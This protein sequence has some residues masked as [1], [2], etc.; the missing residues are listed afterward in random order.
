VQVGP[1][2]QNNSATIT[3]L[4]TGSTQ[5]IDSSV[6]RVA[7]STLRVLL[8]TSQLPSQGFALKQYTFAVWTETQPNA[9]IQDVGSF[10]PEASMIPIGIET[11]V[12][13]TM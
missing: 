12:K 5:A 10:V 1:F 8:N 4:T 13:P 11:D 3:D 7:G 9:P 2:G 6:I